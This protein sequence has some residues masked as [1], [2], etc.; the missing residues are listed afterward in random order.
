MSSD[1][2]FQ[3]ITQLEARMKSDLLSASFS[4][5]CK[6]VSLLLVNET[7]PAILNENNA[8]FENESK[9]CTSNKN[10]NNDP[11]LTNEEMQKIVENLKNPEN[12]RINDN[13]I[14]DNSIDLK[15]NQRLNELSLNLNHEEKADDHLKTSGL[16][17][18]KNDSDSSNDCALQLNAII[19]NTKITDFFFKRNELKKCE[20]NINFKNINSNLENKPD[21]STIDVENNRLKEEIRKLNRKIVEKETLIDQNQNKFKE[22]T[23]ENKMLAS[24]LNK[25]DEAVK[26]FS[27]Y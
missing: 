9:L 21:Y 8:I 11:T 24:E 14:I 16:K 19:N 13:S 15:T 12:I 10:N 25:K 3:K 22:L 5:P 26:V 23:Q 2:D 18:K 7:F 20:K 27:N 1:Q 17:R 4:H 6:K